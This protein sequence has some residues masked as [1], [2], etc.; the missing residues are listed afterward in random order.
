MCLGVGMIYSKTCEYAIRALSCFAGHSEKKWV[1]VEEVS[2]EAGVPCPYVAKIFQCLVQK[3]ILNSHRGPGGGYS[4]MMDPSK[5]TLI[6][7]IQALDDLEKSPFSNCI[8]GLHQC[9]DGN[10]CP[11]HHTWMKAKDK[12][13]KKLSSC[14][15]SDVAG[16]VDK[17]EGG[18]CDRIMLSKSMR[19]MFTV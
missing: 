10:P 7:V 4:L 18:K 9:S 3:K 13:L 11:L 5:I 1:T 15:I 17:F 12:M 16:L 14:S 8:M 6:K 19:A 2:R